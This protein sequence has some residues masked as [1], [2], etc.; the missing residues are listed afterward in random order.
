MDYAVMVGLLGIFT[1][2]LWRVVFVLTRSIQR[3]LDE[4]KAYTREGFAR[5]DQ[6]TNEVKEGLAKYEQ[7]MA[8]GFARQD[9]AMAEGF[10][11][12]DRLMKEGFAKQD[13][14]LDKH[15][16]LIFDLAR[17][18]SLLTGALMGIPAHQRDRE[19]VGSRD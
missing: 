1:A 13:K 15:E 19:K 10:A 9:Q 11:R 8:E 16:A 7:A 4:F 14:R 2:I 5:Q 17:E 12:Q 18:V 3:N 6:A